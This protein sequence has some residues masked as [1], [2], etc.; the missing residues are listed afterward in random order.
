M[1]C[2]LSVSVFF[3]KQKTAYE[4]RI[5]DWSSDVCSSDLSP[6]DR[7][8]S[9]RWPARQSGVS[10]PPAPQ[11]HPSSHKLPNPH[12]SAPPLPCIAEP[13]PPLRPHDSFVRTCGRSLSPP[14]T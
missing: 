1:I 8:S 12:S 13:A 7:S 10:D 3:F 11:S 6:E 14:S 9:L 5:S 2:V 4:M